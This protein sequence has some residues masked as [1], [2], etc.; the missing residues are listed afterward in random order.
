MSIAIDFNTLDEYDNEFLITYATDE[1]KTKRTM[2]GGGLHRD[3]GPNPR[4]KQNPA[5]KIVAKVTESPKFEKNKNGII[6]ITIKYNINTVVNATFTMF[7]LHTETGE[8]DTRGTD[9]LCYIDLIEQPKNPMGDPI[10]SYTDDMVIEKNKK[11]D[12]RTITKMFMHFI[13]LRIPSVEYFVLEDGSVLKFYN[14]KYNSV[15][16]ASMTG[17]YAFEYGKTFYQKTFGGQHVKIVYKRLDRPAK[18]D[19]SS[20]AAKVRRHWEHNRQTDNFFLEYMTIDFNEK[21]S[22]TSYD[23]FV[24]NIIFKFMNTKISESSFFRIYDEHREQRII[25][26]KIR[27]NQKKRQTQSPKDHLLGTQL[28]DELELKDIRRMYYTD[29]EIEFMKDAFKRANTMKEYIEIIKKEAG[30]AFLFYISELTYLIP[31]LIDTEDLNH[32]AIKQGNPQIALNNVE[33]RLLNEDRIKYASSSSYA[34]Y[35]ED[36]KQEKTQE[37]KK[38]DYLRQGSELED[39]F[40]TIPKLSPN[41]RHRYKKKTL[42]MLESHIDN[43]I[44]KQTQHGYNSLMHGRTLIRNDKSQKQLLDEKKKLIMGQATQKVNRSIE[45]KVA[46]L[47]TDNPMSGYSHSLAIKLRDKK[48]RGARKIP[49]KFTRRTRPDKSKPMSRRRTIQAMM[50]NEDEDED[51]DNDFIGHMHDW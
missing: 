24:E 49:S 25:N 8:I 11:G 37:K 31:D 34:K 10:V 51:E 35:L 43:E 21:K 22:G 45:D 16:S 9:K 12:S 14:D 18:T 29:D 1:F 44:K 19:E 4:S 47:E 41:Q 2:A 15:N 3:K 30:D 7:I 6:K 38:I 20:F 46:G 28:T 48:S 42:K 33:V 23:D 17:Y 40:D 50:R 32:L 13:K 26:T 27:E 5:R 39:M 36:Q